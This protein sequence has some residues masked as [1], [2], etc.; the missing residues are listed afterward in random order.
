MKVR[1]LISALGVTLLASGCATAN[2][3]N[4]LNSLMGK[5]DKE[6]FAVLG[7]PNS[8]QTFGSDTVYYWS[9]AANATIFLPQTTNT[10]GYVGS[11][12]VYGT[13]TTNQ[14]TSL[15]Y[16]CTIQLAADSE[17]ILKSWNYDGNIGGCS[18]YIKR[19]KE[20]TKK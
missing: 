20:Y 1:L 13:A 12:P 8:K 15:N 2:M 4:G 16:N 5:P 17:G 19:L 3:E 11:T 18:P 6:A 10:Y 9:R 7:Y 14:P